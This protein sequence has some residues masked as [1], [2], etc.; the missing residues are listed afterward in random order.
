MPW[1]GWLC[2]GIFG[3]LLVA[4]AAAL[5]VALVGLGRASRKLQASLEPVVK[6]LESSSGELQQRSDAFALRQGRLQAST[7]RARG[8]YG[9][10]LVLW[11]ALGEVR[12]GLRVLRYVLVR[13]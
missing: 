11:D 13:R 7:A 3:A 4:G 5:L 1:W 6:E 2:L 8:S 9:D 12:T 10:L